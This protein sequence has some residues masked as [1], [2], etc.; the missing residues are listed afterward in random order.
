MRK[1]RQELVRHAPW[2][3]RKSHSYSGPFSGSFELGE[4]LTKREMAKRTTKT[5]FSLEEVVEQCTR[6]DSD[7]SEDDISDEERTSHLL[8]P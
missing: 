1:V 6:R 3:G 2:G 5:N 8:T 7:E 4:S